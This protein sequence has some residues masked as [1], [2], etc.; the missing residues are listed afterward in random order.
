MSVINGHIKT[1]FE[2]S[3]GSGSTDRP[4]Y[5]C[6]FWYDYGYFAQIYSQTELGIGAPVWIKGVRFRMDENT[7]QES[8]N[9]QTL[10]LGQ[11]NQVEFKSN[12]RNDMIQSPFVDFSTSN[13]TT[14]KSNFTW[15]IFNIGA[16]WKEIIFDTPFRYDPTITNKHLLL[17]WENRDGSYSSGS[18]SPWSEC[19]TSGSLARSYYDYQDNSMPPTT[20]YGTADS[21]GRPNAQFIFEV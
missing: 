11:V 2:K 19:S 18:G 9:N 6:Y 3:I 8:A 17:V 13:I 14:V 21:T 5:P 15:T 10:K 20:D 4:E 7:G 12:V 1:K 16:V